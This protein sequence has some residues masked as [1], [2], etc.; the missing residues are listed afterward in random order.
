MT[1]PCTMWISARIKRAL[2]L[3]PTLVTL[4]CA[5]SETGNAQVDRPLQP[6]GLAMSLASNPG[7]FSSVSSDDVDVTA[8][9]GWARVVGIDLRLA[10]GERC[11][12]D[13]VEAQTTG[14]FYHAWCN[15]G[16][17]LSLD[18][19]WEVDL[20]TGLF[21]PPLEQVQ[22]PEAMIDEVRVT[23]RGDGEPALDLVGTLDG[24]RAFELAM[25]GTIPARFAA[26]AAIAI[27]EETGM[28]VLDLDFASWFSDIALE[29]CLDSQA[30]DAVVEL[31][32]GSRCASVEGAV[33]NHLVNHGKLNALPR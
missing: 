17:G 8:R 2:Y 19:D 26:A 25:H 15:S 7:G 31:G 10:Q 9:L 5:G 28:L 3:G 1:Q 16:S 24:D 11:S 18:G 4:G 12:D 14:A 21:E 27:D 6:V 22:I 30:T 33:R 23:L 13:R 20:V 32:R 29:D